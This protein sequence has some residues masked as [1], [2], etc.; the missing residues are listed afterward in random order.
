MKRILMF[1]ETMGS[2]VFTLVSQLCND[3]CDEFEI[4]LA[5]STRRK[6]T[7]KDFYNYFDSRVHLIEV[8]S[9]NKTSLSDISNDIKIIK[10]L[11]KIEREV[12]PDIIH[13]HSSIAGGL[14]RIAFKGKKNKVV[15]TPHGYAH[16][17]GGP[18]L[19]STMFFCLEKILGS[20]N[21]ITLTC[22]KSEDEEA[23]KVS[24][25]TFYAETGVN[26]KD[27]D[28]SLNGVAPVKNDR[29]TVYCLGRIA[30]QKRPD[31][32][33]EI[34]E[35]VPEARFLWIGD[36]D[37]R[38]K[39]V[40]PNIEITGWKA[41]KEALALAKGTDVF[42][43]CSFGEAIA[44]SLIENMYLK[45][46][47]LVSDTM[48]NKSVIQD[49]VNGYVCNSAEEYARHIREAMEHFPVELTERA[50]RDVQEIYNTEC[51]KEKYRNFYNDLCAFR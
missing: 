13:L 40:S 22:C 16:V 32:F 21:S 31:L 3:L 39:F 14:G 27:L 34:A 38:D 23:K 20:G 10:E 11:R 51:M 42:L 36:G 26:I 45:K 33:N 43:L 8:K 47:C 24:K 2:G 37:L 29:F 7:P 25:R 44:M 48:G 50:Y 5:Y 4:F 49:G 9:L 6:E 1:T 15:Y 12:N 19:K 35:M 30:K 41:R 28:E 18:G 46:L 17:L